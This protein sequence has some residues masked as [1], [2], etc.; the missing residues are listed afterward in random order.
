MPSG[1]A[2]KGAEL[3]PSK[4]ILGR[5]MSGFMTLMALSFLW[6]KPLENPGFTEVFE[7]WADTWVPSASLGWSVSLLI[8]VMLLVISYLIGTFEQKTTFYLYNR[9]GRDV[10]WKTDLGEIVESYDIFFGFNTNE[11]IKSFISPE[12][13]GLRHGEPHDDRMKLR[14]RDAR[15]Y[16]LRAM[17]MYVAT[18][19]QEVYKYLISIENNKN[20]YSAVIWLSSVIGL[21]S[22]YLLCAWKANML[23]VVIVLAVVSALLFLHLFKVANR[24]EAREIILAYLAV[25]ATGKTSAPPDYTSSNN[26][27][28][29]HSPPG[30]AAP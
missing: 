16:T 27:A 21:V 25:M 22:I 2:E 1:S 9:Y 14:G 5:L 3:L 10:Y 19:N 13:I 17:R 28:P 8:A 20:L 12:V 18:R 15:D 26:T 11:I 30:T 24:Q 7:K 6:V 23:V 29:H 4:D